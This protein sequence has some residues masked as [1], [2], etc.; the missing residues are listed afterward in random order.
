MR[1]VFLGTPE[2]AVPALESL[3]EY[4]CDVPAVFAQPDRPAGRGRKVRPGPV[5]FLAESRGLTV[6][7]PEKIRAEENREVFERLR[8]DYIVTAAYGQILPGWVLASARRQALNVHASL[9]PRYRGAAPVAWSIL[10]GDRVSGVTLMVMEEALDAGP[11]LLQREVPIGLETTTGELSRTLAREG[12]EL[13][14]ETLR[15]LERGALRPLPQDEAR[16]TWA[17]RLTK[18]MAPV[19]WDRSALEVHNRI[20]ALDP[21]PGART[22]FCAEPLL[23]WRSL[24]EE[25]TGFGEAE[26]GRLLSL[27]ERGIRVQCGGGSVLEL[28]EVQRPGKGRVS[29]REFAS[30]ARV[31]PGDVIFH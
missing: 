16:A 18:E 27:S 20:R 15:Q 24:P 7:Q 25:L 3:L 5:K 13:L 6:H 19:S 11:I 28:L 30:G 14:V 10:N 9:L 21:W 29:G 4:G 1:V 12:A 8:A 17:P 31:R 23:L 2:F 26:P 22:L